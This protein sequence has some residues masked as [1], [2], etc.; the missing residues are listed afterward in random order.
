VVPEAGIEPAWAFWARGILSSDQVQRPCSTICA[1]LKQI[2]KLER[3]LPT[4]LPSRIPSPICASGK[5]RAKQLSSAGSSSPEIHGPQ[6]T[7]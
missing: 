3:V 7:R 5:V 6:E 2:E 1:D 4:P